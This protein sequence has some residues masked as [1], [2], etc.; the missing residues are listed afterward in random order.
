MQEG[1]DSKNVHLTRAA[2]LLGLHQ[3]Q[4]FPCCYYYYYKTTYYDS[5]YIYVQLMKVQTWNGQITC[6]A[7]SL[8]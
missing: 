4:P 6:K 8:S 7:F 2:L 1:I 3:R 5:L